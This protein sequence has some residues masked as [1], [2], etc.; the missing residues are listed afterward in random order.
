MNGVFNQRGLNFRLIIEQETFNLPYFE[1]LQ[2][3]DSSSEDGYFQ[4]DSESSSFFSEDDFSSSEEE[5]QSFIIDDY[6]DMI[7]AVQSFEKEIR[8]KKS[9]TDKER[10]ISIVENLL[11]K[12]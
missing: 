10:I 4:S 1:V 12:N 7:E 8:K 3:S 2:E 6:N 11:N 9:Q 5:E